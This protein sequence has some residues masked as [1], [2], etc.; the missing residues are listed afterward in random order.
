VTGGATSS[1]GSDGRRTKETVSYTLGKRGFE[2]APEAVTAD[3]VAPIE[4]I[5][6]IN[7]EADDPNRRGKKERLDGEDA[8]LISKR[9]RKSSLPK[10]I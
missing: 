4:N 8:D 1:V 7:G 10:H 2:S 9:K 6:P 3:P 5:T